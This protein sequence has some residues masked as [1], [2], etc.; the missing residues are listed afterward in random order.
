ML[1]EESVSF[2][3]TA[4][5]MN[6]NSWRNCHGWRLCDTWRTE[7]NLWTSHIHPY[8]WAPHALT[9]S[10]LLWLL[11]QHVSLWAPPWSCLAWCPLVLL[12]WSQLVLWYLY[13]MNSTLKDLDDQ[14]KPKSPPSLSLSLSKSSLSTDRCRGTA[15]LFVLSVLMS[16]TFLLLLPSPQ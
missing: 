13:H 10:V 12:F 9:S 4:P 8:P 16:I 5:G 3:R 14:P 2:Q 11:I 1:K 6:V 7:S 15:V